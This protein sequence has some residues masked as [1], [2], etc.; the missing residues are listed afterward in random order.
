MF[1]FRSPFS[2]LFIQQNARVDSR[3]RSFIR[4]APDGL[5]ATCFLS[6]DV[7]LIRYSVAGSFPVL[8]NHPVGS[9][10]VAACVFGFTCEKRA[11]NNMFG[12]FGVSVNNMFGYFGV[13]VLGG[14]QA[15]F[16][17]LSR[18]SKFANDS[19]R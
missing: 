1:W 9:Y 4:F 17:M 10:S 18:N 19:E 16:H 15:K 5:A 13:S 14:V 8:W 12:Y 7:R 3:P 11:A 2:T 6:I